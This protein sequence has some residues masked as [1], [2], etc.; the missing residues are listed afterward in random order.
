MKPGAA[1]GAAI[2]F[3]FR[4]LDASC[5]SP[6]KVVGLAFGEVAE[7]VAL[8]YRVYL[9]QDSPNMIEADATQITG[10]EDGKDKQGFGFRLT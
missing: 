3:P 5:H 8:L 4:V 9:I 1:R 10:T 2:I 6:G 7:K